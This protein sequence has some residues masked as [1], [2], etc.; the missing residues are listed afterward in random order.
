MWLLPLLRHL[1]MQMKLNCFLMHSTNSR[2][3]QKLLVWTLQV[4]WSVWTGLMTPRKTGK[5]FLMPVWCPILMKINAI[6]NQKN[7]EGNDYSIRVYSRNDSE[8][9]NVCSHGRINSSGYCCDLSTTAFI[10][11]RWSSWPTPWLI[12]GTFANHQPNRQSGII[13][14]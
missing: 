4:L 8:P 5:W 9:L 11:T 10:T 6:E 7:A 14:F 12:S 2:T 13:H 1:A 3:L